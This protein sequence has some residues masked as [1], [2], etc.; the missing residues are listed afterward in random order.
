MRADNF[1]ESIVRY[2]EKDMNSGE[3]FAFE[4]LLQSDPDL[5]QTFLKQKQIW[6]KLED[7]RKQQRQ[8]RLA[9]KQSPKES[10]IVS[11]FKANRNFAAAAC[12]IA[13][14]MIPIFQKWELKGLVSFGNP[15]SQTSKQSIESWNYSEYIGGKT[16]LEQYLKTNLQYPKAAREQ[17]IQGVVIVEFLVNTDGTIQD[18][19]IGKGIGGGCDEE[20]IRLVQ[21]MPH[22]KAGHQKLPYMVAVKFEIK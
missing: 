7:L 20:A 16:E 21:N 11:F 13:V 1:S 5:N 22:W 12:L 6:K 4:Q 15:H 17:G 19:K 2:L 8:K 9:A 3:Q 14:A 10:K 18:A